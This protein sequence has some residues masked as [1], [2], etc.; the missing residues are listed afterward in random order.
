VYSS[1][2]GGS[3]LILPFIYRSVPQ[4]TKFSL[5]FWPAAQPCLGSP[6]PKGSFFLLS[7]RNKKHRLKIFL[8]KP[9]VWQ[10]QC[11]PKNLL[12]RI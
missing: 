12:G 2:L 1:D 6:P 4:Q 7:K 9:V 3:K 11:N 5:L 8:L 10:G